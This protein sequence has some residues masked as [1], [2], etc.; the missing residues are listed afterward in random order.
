MPKD[1]QM[2]Q[3]A[4]GLI[5]DLGDGVARRAAT[6]LAGAVGRCA[7]RIDRDEASASGGVDL[8][9]RAAGGIEEVEC[10]PTVPV[11]RALQSDARSHCLSDGDHRTTFGGQLH[12]IPQ[13]LRLDQPGFAHVPIAVQETLALDRRQVQKR[14]RVFV[15]CEVGIVGEQAGKEPPIGSPIGRLTPF[16]RLHDESTLDPVV[17]DVARVAG[18]ANPQRHIDRLRPAQ[19]D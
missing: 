5:P 8:D 16:A 4:A 10:G 14:L 11:G 6:A 1:Q 18:R 17:A 19:T 3:L 2:R 7:G 9:E 13:P 15:G 12:V